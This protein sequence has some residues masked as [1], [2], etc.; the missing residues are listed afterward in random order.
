MA[1]RIVRQPLESEQDKKNA[2]LF[3]LTHCK[4]ENKYN[5]IL[6]NGYNE[7]GETVGFVVDGYK[8]YF[9]LQFHSDE[10]NPIQYPDRVRSYLI[11]LERQVRV[12]KSFHIPK[13]GD[14][15]G[16]E[17]Q[18][19]PIF[20]EKTLPDADNFHLIS[21]WAAVDEQYKTMYG[22]TP[23]MLK[24]IIQVWVNQPKVCDALNFFIESTTFSSSLPKENLFWDTYPL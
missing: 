4:Y 14:I 11:W 5:K 15:S 24:N 9:F 17:T 22:W 7:K 12:L 13:G 1:R 8:R 20:S 18:Y 2:M 23:D 21:H 19:N 3:Y 10:M 6:M 16:V